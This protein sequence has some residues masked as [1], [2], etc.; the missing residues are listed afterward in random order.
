M[1]IP[2]EIIKRGNAIIYNDTENR[3]GLVKEIEEY[4]GEMWNCRKKMKQLEEIKFGYIVLNPL[5]IGVF[6][7]TEATAF[8]SNAPLAAVVLAINIAAFVIFAVFK[9][10]YLISTIAVA[11]FV[12]ADW[13]L[14]F[15][16][17]ADVVIYLL[18]VNVE[19]PLKNHTGY[20]FFNDIHIK[21]EN[22]NFSEIDKYDR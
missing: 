7:A 13:R 18:R 11:L 9:S 16:F 15:L 14:I 5:V 8:F 2:E 1:S 20:P 12:L 21:Y 6:I 17:A 4:N 19:K 3:H 22:K 10:N